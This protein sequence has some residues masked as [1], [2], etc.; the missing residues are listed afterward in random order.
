MCDSMAEANSTKKTTKKTNTKKTTT[1]RKN[2]S[3]SSSSKKVVKSPS[4]STSAKK[5]VVVQK[6]TRST[7]NL[8]VYIFL[9]SAVWI[10]LYVMSRFGL[11]I[12]G[13]TIGY[14]TI[15]L[16][17]IYFITN[18]ITKKFDFKQSIFAIL[19]SSVAMLIFVYFSRFVN[20]KVVDYFIIYGQVFAYIMSQLI[21]L[22]IYYYLLVNTDL[23][24]RWIFLTYLFST[25]VYYF[26]AIL[27][28][29]R[30]V[31]ASAFWPTFF[32]SIGFST[33]FA[34]MYS[35]YDSMIQRGQ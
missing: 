21:N 32:T 13:L 4:K 17:T 12:H 16:P 14:S 24:A 23:K 31:F 3:K 5:E 34:I 33:I 27:F 7:E 30:L 19:I 9:L 35:F 28:S 6:T 15:L 2:V 22:I 20:T 11:V 10:C 29:T 26:I 8:Y 1:K 18:V 25:M